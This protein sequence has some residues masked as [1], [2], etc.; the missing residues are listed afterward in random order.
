MRDE[1]RT[2]GGQANLFEEAMLWLVGINK[3]SDFVAGR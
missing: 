2:M 3:K 1:S